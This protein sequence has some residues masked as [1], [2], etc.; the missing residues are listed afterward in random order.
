M[1]YY[2]VCDY[3]LVLDN[4]T[5]KYVAHKVCIDY[6]DDM[7]LAYELYDQGIC[8]YIAEFTGEALPI[9]ERGFFEYGDGEVYSNDQIAFVQVRR[10]PTLFIQAYPDMDDL[11]EDFKNRVGQYL[12][13]DFDYRNHIRCIIGAYL[14]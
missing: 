12:P 2:A 10:W 13:E 6:S 9:D 5:M 14:G 3:G 11:I 4:E 1:R 8:E 7:D